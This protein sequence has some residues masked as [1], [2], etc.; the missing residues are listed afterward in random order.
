MNARETIACIFA[1][2]GAIG[3]A[4]FFWLLHGIAPGSSP[5]ASDDWIIL[6]VLSA[7]VFGFPVG[8]IAGDL[9]ADCFELR[10]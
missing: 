3:A 2:L 9:V 5:I 8:Y 1:A 7:A 10:R 6:A 4:F